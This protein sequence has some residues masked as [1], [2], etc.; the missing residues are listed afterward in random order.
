[1]GRHKGSRWKK[2]K[3]PDSFLELKL[4]EAEAGGQI[5]GDLDGRM[6]LSEGHWKATEG[7]DVI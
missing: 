7:R 6:I 3:E 4:V 2:E 1:M 5:T